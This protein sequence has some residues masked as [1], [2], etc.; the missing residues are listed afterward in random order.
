MFVQF[1][2]VIYIL[3]YKL[4]ST[5][6]QTCFIVIF[7]QMTEAISFSTRRVPNSVAGNVKLDRVK[8]VG[9]QRA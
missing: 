3:K 4:Y 9:V 2:Y 7:A 5:L 8:L 6:L 1:V